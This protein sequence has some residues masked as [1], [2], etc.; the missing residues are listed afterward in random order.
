MKRDYLAREADG[1]RQGAVVGTGRRDLA[2]L[3]GY[4][5]KTKRQIPVFVLEPM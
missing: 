1:R 5:K 3:R 2:R 4:Q